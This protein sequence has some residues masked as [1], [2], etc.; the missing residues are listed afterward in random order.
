MLKYKFKHI[1]KHHI[2]DINEMVYRLSKNY[3]STGDFCEGIDNILDVYLANDKKETKT[4][5]P[6]NLSH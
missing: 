5:I 1:E 6:E 3:I 2:K 4:N